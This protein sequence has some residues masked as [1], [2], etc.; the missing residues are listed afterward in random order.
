MVRR[1]SRSGP[2][3]FFGCGKLKRRW[4]VAAVPAILAWLFMTEWLSL[5]VFAQDAL[6]PPTLMVKRC[7]DFTVTGQGDA[8]AWQSTDWVKMNRRTNGVHDYESR[9]KMLYS[10]KG[11]Y[12]LF[13]ATDKTLTATMEADFLDLWHEDVFECFF[14]TSETQTLY[15]EYEISPLGF[16]LPIL[17]PN[18][19]G[20]FLG[21]R[22]WHYEG[23]RKT[24]KKIAVDGGSP[25]P[26]ASVKSWQAE[27]FIPYDLLKPLAGVPPKSGSHWRANFYRMDYDDGQTSAWQWAPVGASF[28]EFKKFGTLTFE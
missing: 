28:H 17:V 24:Q 8:A 4:E 20:N 21:W 5:A 18:L 19:D 22:P 9:F 10:S 7:D 25:R 13:A 23:E 6:S 26:L 14:W 15:F 11:V 2:P 1:T 12:V 16:E 3:V 27:V